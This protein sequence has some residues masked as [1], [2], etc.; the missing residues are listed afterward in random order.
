MRFP[1]IS[2]QD[3]ACACKRC[4]ADAAFAGEEQMP[5]RGRQKFWYASHR[6]GFQHLHEVSVSPAL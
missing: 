1:P 6:L 3:S 4:L 5:R 2:Q